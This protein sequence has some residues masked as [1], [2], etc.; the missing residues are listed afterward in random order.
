MAL[1]VPEPTLT[2][3]GVIGA[4][5]GS[6]KPINLLCG[7]VTLPGGKTLGPTTA[8]H[9]GYLLFRETAP[10]LVAV[11]DEKNQTWSPP[12]TTVEEQQLFPEEPMWKSILVAVGQKDSAGAD[13]FATNAL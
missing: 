4:V 8:T 9:F 10:G 2:S 12:A 5:L 13:K 3:P 7:P 1:T 11:W 6:E